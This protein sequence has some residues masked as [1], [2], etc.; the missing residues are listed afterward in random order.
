MSVTLRALLTVILLPWAFSKGRRFLPFA[1]MTLVLFWMIWR[2]ET[3]KAECLR[4]EQCLSE[5]QPPILPKTVFFDQAIPFPC[6]VP[7]SLSCCPRR[8]LVFDDAVA[9]TTSPGSR[10]AMEIA[11]SW[12]QGLH[13]SYCDN[14]ASCS[15]PQLIR[16][17]TRINH[18]Q[19]GTKAMRL[20]WPPIPYGNSRGAGLRS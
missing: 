6:G 1:A 16:R 12:Y 2:G 3:W 7:R 13:R 20:V 10:Y 8:P 11:E 9:Q 15:Q 18:T 5:P 17:G 19:S 14:R 4:L